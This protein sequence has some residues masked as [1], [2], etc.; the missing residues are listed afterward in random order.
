MTAP[1]PTRSSLRTSTA[2]AQAKVSPLVLADRLIS[3]AQDADR[4]GLRGP[5]ENLVRLA[6]D[7]C[8]EQPPAI[9]LS[10]AWPGV[11]RSGA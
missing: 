11:G 9:G 7:I 2:A 4:A 8:D 1:F 6:I 3:L 5:A 10:D